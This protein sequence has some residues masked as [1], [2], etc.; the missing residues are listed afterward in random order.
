MFLPGYHNTPAA[1][2]L[3]FKKAENFK[4]FQKKEAGV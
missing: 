2:R 3:V 1:E 4:N